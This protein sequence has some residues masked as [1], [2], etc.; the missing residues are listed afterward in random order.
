MA[1]LARAQVRDDLLS[2]LINDVDVLMLPTVGFPV[3]P[4]L[5]DS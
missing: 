3:S 2:A 5:D 1:Q 4:V